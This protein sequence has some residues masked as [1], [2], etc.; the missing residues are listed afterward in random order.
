MRR[1][2]EKEIMK[3]YSRAIESELDKL[4]SRQN[5]SVVVKVD[6]TDRQIGIADKL[7]AHAN[8]GVLHRAF[9]IFLFDLSGRLLLQRR[10][11]G[12]YHF[13]GLWTN[14]CCGHAVPG[15][16]LRVTAGI[17]LWQEMGICAEIN[18]VGH[19]TYAA[20]DPSSG[21]T[22]REIDHIFIGISDTEP[23]PDPDEVSEWRWIAPNDLSNELAT[24]PSTFT[25][26]FGL[27][28]KALR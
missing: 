28:L 11:C 7:D 14:T 16:E 17:R 10:A 12:K 6:E 1:A 20:T 4:Y 22:E 26:W 19:F 2:R 5:P 24:K 21:L 18:E 15:E 25:P 13:G 23:S 9:S 27:G 8:G 3:D